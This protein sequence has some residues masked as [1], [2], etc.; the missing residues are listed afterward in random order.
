VSIF[1]RRFRHRTLGVRDG[2]RYESGHHS[3]DRRD[4]ATADT[5][6][7][8]LGRVVVGTDL[9]FSAGMIV[10]S[11]LPMLSSEEKFLVDKEVPSVHSHS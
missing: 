11:R 6:A 2:S 8:V 1:L 3:D 9:G 10:Y 5:P 4:P 7:D